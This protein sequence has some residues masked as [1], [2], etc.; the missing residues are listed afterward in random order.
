MEV[1]VN[2]AIATRGIS[3]SA[4]GLEHL[5]RA[6]HG[7]SGVDVREVWPG[8]RLRRS[9]WWNA[10]VQASWDLARAAHSARS[11]DV[12]VSPCNVGR[13]R[14]GQRHVLVLHD[15]TVLDEPQFFDRGYAAYARATFGL[16]VRCA[17][18]IIVPSSFT[19]GRVRARWPDA[20]PA[21]VAYWPLEGVKREDQHWERRRPI[22]M[23]GST[24]AHKNHRLAIEAVATARAASGEDL[25]L[26]VV[27][28][29]GRAESEVSHALRRHDPSGSWTTRLRAVSDSELAGCYAA[30]W[31]LLQPS[32]FEGY[33]LPVGE[34]SIHGV[35]SVHSGRGALSEIAPGA[36]AQPDRPES[37]AQALCS[38]LDDTVYRK[39]ATAAYDRSSRLTPARFRSDVVTVLTGKPPAP[40]AASLTSGAFSAAR[41]GD[42]RQAHAPT[43]TELSHGETRPRP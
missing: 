34:A 33:G 38:L 15:T 35:P 12:L 14:A 22:L 13:A 26:L 30:A 5:L 27:G 20:P 4:R 40:S 25:R 11:A 28:P 16:S 19:L 10:S 21:K 6:L 31:V 23:V 1:A 17:D 43:R 42:Q 24:E 7:A 32:R 29:E 3:G 8:Y 18:A 39:A 41:R 36:V 2:C 9:R 37:Y